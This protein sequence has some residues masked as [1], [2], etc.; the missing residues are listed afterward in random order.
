M[1]SQV[2]Q[3]EVVS[4]LEPGEVD[5]LRAIGRDECVGEVGGMDRQTTYAFVDPVELDLDVVA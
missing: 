5:E 4:G 1:L 3:P 2:L